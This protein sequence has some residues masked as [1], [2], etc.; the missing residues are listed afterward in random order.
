MPP[1]NRSAAAVQPAALAIVSVP[2]GELIPYIGNARLHSDA[3]VAQIAASIQE[4]GFNVPVLVD[5]KGSI[6]A[7]HGRVQAAQRLGMDLVPAIRLGHLTPAQVR[8][9]RLADNQIALNSTWDDSILAAELRALAAEDFD[10]ALTGFD[11]SALQQLLAGGGS[12]GGGDPDADAPEPPAVPV[13]RLA[14]SIDA[15]AGARKA[16]L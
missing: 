13:S 5:A 3:Q 10:L 6:V 2:I 8:A 4:F 12:G 1:R 11:D 14:V 9:Y 16:C 15:C 7:G